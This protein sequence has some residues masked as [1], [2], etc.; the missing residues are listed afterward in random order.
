MEVVILQ[1][2]TKDRRENHFLL[3]K[4]FPWDDSTSVLLKQVTDE[5]ILYYPYW[6]LSSDHT[7]DK[8]LS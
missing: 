3:R 2:E 8:M 7:L 6:V 1:G 4:I 5:I